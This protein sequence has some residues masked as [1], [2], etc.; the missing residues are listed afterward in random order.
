MSIDLNVY[1]PDV[2]AGLLSKLIAR[3]ADLGLDCEICPGFTLDKNSNDGFLPIRMRFV[4]A[5]PLSCRG[6]DYLTGFECSLSD[7]SYADEL[8]KVQNPQKPNFLQ[9]LLFQQSQPQ[10]R[11]YISDPD[12]D[13]FLKKCKKVF[14]INYHHENE[15]LISFAF[16]GILAELADGIIHDPQ[17]DDYIF[18]QSALADISALIDEPPTEE[19]DEFDGWQTTQH[20]R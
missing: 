7:F 15:M 10:S 11:N 1:M 18:P 13:D 6:K 4:N 17:V 8:K 9:K 5:G 14:Q 2:K 12:T 19:W 3:L 16:A 20:A